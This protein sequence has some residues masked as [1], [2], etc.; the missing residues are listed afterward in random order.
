MEGEHVDQER[1]VYKA[2]MEVMLEHA[3]YSQQK[4]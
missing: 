2:W 1:R 4:A 3:N